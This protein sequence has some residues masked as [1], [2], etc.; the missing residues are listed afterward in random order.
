MAALLDRFH[1]NRHALPAYVAADLEHEIDRREALS[2]TCR[3]RL[4][5]MWHAG[6]DGRPVCTWAVNAASAGSFVLDLPSG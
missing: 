3:P 2:A 6:A 1:L 4:V 5:A